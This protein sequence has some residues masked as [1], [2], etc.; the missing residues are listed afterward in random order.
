MYYK[1]S[2]GEIYPAV[3][4]RREITSANILE[5]EAG[6]TGFKGGDTGHGGRTY[7]R[8]KD[9]AGTDINVNVVTNKFGYTDE[10]EITLGGDTELATFIEALKWAAGVL[11]IKSAE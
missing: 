7:L 10:L 5:V 1:D 9:L 2:D 11:E 6:T 4:N 8:I 3:K